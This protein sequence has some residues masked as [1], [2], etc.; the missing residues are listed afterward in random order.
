MR[1]LIVFAVVFGLLPLAFLRPYYGLL[2]FTWL[3]YM[4]APD[5]AWGPARSFRFSLMVA[6]VMFTGWLLFDRHKFFRRDRRCYYMLA[7]VVT[8]TISYILAPYKVGSVPSKFVEF[9]KVIAIALF[10]TAQIDSRS[11]LRQVVWLITLSLGFY[12][13]KGGLWFL[14]TQDARIIQGPGGL[15]LDNNDFSLAMCMNLPFLFY[16]AHAE[17]NRRVKMF[18][19]VVLVLTVLTIMMTGSRGGFLSM[20]ATFGM[21]TLK[22]RYKTVAFS[23]AF[24]GALIFVMIMPQDYRDRLMTLKSAH[25]TDASALGRIHAWGIALKMIKAKPLF[26]IGF[27]NFVFEYGRYDDS[28]VP[29][30][31][32]VAHNS[33]LQI[34]A[35]SGTFSLLFFLGVMGSTWLLMMRM[36]RLNRAYRGPPWITHYGHMIECSLTAFVV[37]AMFLNRAHFDMLYQMCAVAVAMFWVAWAEMRRRPDGKRSGPSH[38]VVRHRDPFLVGSWR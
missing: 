33:Y 36:R 23:T 20:V 26:G 38:L 18:L 6:A 12:G 3:A 31:H 13:A 19:R 11:R 7:L 35:E 32:R 21:I 1:D 17:P 29:N 30:V 34:W 8:V 25:K 22:S 15:L 4:R 14:I 9:V 10:T 37:G 16:L 28:V 24:V 2:L 5:L 27:N